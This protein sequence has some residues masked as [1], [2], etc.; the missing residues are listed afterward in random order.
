ML[1]NHSE[2][3]QNEMRNRQLTQADKIEL[4]IFQNACGNTV[5]LKWRLAVNFKI[6]YKLIGTDMNKENIHSF[7]MHSTT[8]SFLRNV[9]IHSH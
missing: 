1:S 5:Y 7:K 6:R 9:T 8:E 3:I 4:H 2:V